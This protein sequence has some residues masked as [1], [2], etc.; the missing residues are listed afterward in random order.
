[1]YSKYYYAIAQILTETHNNDGL[2]QK[3]DE[4]GLSQT[5]IEEIV[6]NNTFKETNLNN[7]FFK[8]DHD[9]NIWKKLTQK[10]KNGKYIS[11]LKHIPK[12]PLTILEK[13][14]L[15]SILS[16]PKMKLFFSDTEQL[17]NK[18]P[19]LNDV[20]PLYSSDTF[21][22]F[23]Q[24]SNADPYEDSN[25][26]EFFRTIINAKEENK[27]LNIQFRDKSN[28]EHNWNCYVKNLE[29]SEKENKFRV[30]V[31]YNNKCKTI[32]LS[33]ITSCTIIDNTPKKEEITLE[34]VDKHNALDRVMLSFSDLEMRTEKTE[35]TDY[36]TYKVTLY[37]EKDSEEEIIN[38]ILAFVNNL[39]VTGDENKGKLIS[40]NTPKK[41]EITLELIEKHNA[42]DRVMLSFSDLE[43]RTEK[44][45]KTEKT[46]DNN[47]KVTL[48]SEKE[49]INRILAF[50]NNL[51][52]TGDE[53]K[54]KLIS[55]NTPKKEEIT[56]EL[57]DKHNALDRVMLSFS[58]LEKRTEK[59]DK[60]KYKVTLYYEKDS[61]K[62]IIIRIL[63]FGSNL[64][65]I[66]DEDK[67]EL[68]K[69]RIKNQKN[70][71]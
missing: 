58:D 57:I 63:A 30:I 39:K 12:K 70:C 7:D 11:R 28:K 27:Q 20:E 4:V 40:D 64:K 38:R 51:K 71:F 43:K 53:N 33:R 65:V 68:I 45:E 34:L 41:E 15:K 18:L 59:T 56:L 50:V 37:Y 3:D 23:D 16:D 60:N 48:Y 9:K 22:Y 52:V 67:V 13:R 42:L 62:E 24:H 19:F 31:F 25:Y 69:V 47:Y 61:E 8:N 29:Y 17:K 2:N 6:K 66:G 5:D 21:V 35:K 1:M 55:D 26:Q 49:I 54:V 44:T 46:G 14:W 10:N 32:N 36:D